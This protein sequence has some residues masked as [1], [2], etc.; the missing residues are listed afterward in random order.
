MAYSHSPLMIEY[1]IM[2]P[3][4][5]LRLPCCTSHDFWYFRIILPD[6]ISYLSDNTKT[7]SGI[8]CL[9]DKSSHIAIV[10]H[11]AACWII[12]N[13]TNHQYF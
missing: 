4:Y 5:T 12:V 6:S 8:S 7:M 11:I 13:A 2:Y 9:Y 1:I 10:L 3:V